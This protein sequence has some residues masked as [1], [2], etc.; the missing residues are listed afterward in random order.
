MDKLML[1]W[2]AEGQHQ[3]HT[4]TIGGQA[5]IGRRS[6]CTI[7]IKSETI[8]RQHAIV[9]SQGGGFYIR[10]LSRVNPVRIDDNVRLGFNEVSPLLPGNVIRIGPAEFQIKGEIDPTGSTKPKIRCLN[11]NKV[12]DYDPKGF[13]PWCGMALA[14]GQTVMDL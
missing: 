6:D 13:C 4:I 9:F 14:A 1:Q 2:H 11:C 12:Q 10:N 5:T 7:V 3:S 8:S